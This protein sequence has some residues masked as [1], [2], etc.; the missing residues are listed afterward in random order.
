MLL[1]TVREVAQWGVSCPGR[2][3]EADF[4]RAFPSGS[5]PVPPSGLDRLTAREREILKKF[6]QGRTYAEIA[7][8]RGNNP[9]TVRNAVYA[10]QRKLG[11]WVPGR[12]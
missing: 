9:M 12:S 7:E 10:I 2:S 6:A 5:N 1:S 8:V 11:A 4:W 3:G